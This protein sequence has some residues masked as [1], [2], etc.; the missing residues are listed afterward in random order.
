MYNE[1]GLRIHDF[2]YFW[3]STYGMQWWNSRG[4]YTIGSNTPNLNNITHDI[5]I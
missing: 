5:S 3:L 2:V 4:S 1:H